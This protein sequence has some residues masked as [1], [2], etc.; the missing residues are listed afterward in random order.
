MDSEE[1]KERFYTK[2]LHRIQKE[3]RRNTVL[4]TIETNQ[5][6]A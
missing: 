4:E 2:N 1:E 3:A 5:I 6:A